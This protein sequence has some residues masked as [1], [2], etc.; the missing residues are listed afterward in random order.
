MVVLGAHS[1]VMICKINWSDGRTLAPTPALK[2]SSLGTMLGMLLTV[3]IFFIK[4]ELPAYCPN[5]TARAW[6]ILY[7]QIVIVW[8]R[9]EK[10]IEPCLASAQIQ[11][12][13]S[14]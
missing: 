12:T 14:V 5:Y 2:S 9:K 7:L 4:E 13:M 8:I 1:S 11:Y 3:N 6:L 10:P